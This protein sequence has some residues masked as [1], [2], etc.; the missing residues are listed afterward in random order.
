MPIVLESNILFYLVTILL[1]MV[2]SNLVKNSFNRGWSLSDETKVELLL[3]LKAFFIVFGVLKWVTSSAIF[4]Y[5]VETAHEE[6]QKR[7]NTVLE[8]IGGKLELPVEF[9]YAIMST[10]AAFIT[11]S[12]VRT[13]IKFSYYFFMLTKTGAMFNNSEDKV[14]KAKYRK[15]MGLIYFNLLAPLVITILYIKPLIQS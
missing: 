8:L 10:I 5:D 15:L 4:D 2:T 11:F 7:I 12:I 13:N 1:L 9:T 14:Q 3:S 6:T